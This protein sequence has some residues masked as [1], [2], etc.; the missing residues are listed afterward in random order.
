MSNREL[1]SEPLDSGAFE[2][3]MD[4]FAPSNA[5]RV[6]VAVSGGADSM[7]L[8]LLLA[9]WGRARGVEVTALSVDHGLR[10]GSAVE[11]QQVGAWLADA[12][13]EQHILTWNDKAALT[14]G[15]Q[16]RARD[17]RYALMA[18][19][20]QT[21]GVK[22][23]FVAH[24]LGDQAETFVM[25]LKRAS[26][27]FG[28]AAM[29]P[30]RELHGAAVCRPL[31]GVT[32]A[33]LEA[34]LRARGQAWVVDPSNANP[35]FERVRTRALIEH[36]G[37]QGV[38]PERLA[39]A[40]HGAGRLVQILD[41]AVAA[42][43]QTAVTDRLGGG[44]T[45]DAEAFRTLPQTLRERVLSGL[46]VQVSGQAYAPSPDKLA[47][48]AQWM[49]MPEDTVSRARTLGRCVVRRAGGGFH[50][51][52]EPPRKRFRQAKKASFIACAPLPRAAK[53]L[54]SRP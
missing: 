25:R 45:V 32:K 26:T 20:C 18:D 53:H 24:H 8:A 51:L 29:A 38:S 47:R 23:L 44:F 14:S 22:A 48:F 42:F 50:I 1:S 5:A 40:A 13:I 41:R 52:P 27:L 39:G 4:P 34:T 11:A 30:V 31:L 49:A 33:R 6:A 35:A 28:L 10:E 9:D 15:V 19:W 3:L 12:G 37:H 16:A 43:A 7:A 46:L 36:L 54:T 17:A 2:R 21:H